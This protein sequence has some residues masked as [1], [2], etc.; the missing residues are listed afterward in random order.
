[1]TNAPAQ[2]ELHNPPGPHPV[3]AP[4]GHRLRTMSRRRALLWAGLA[5]SLSIHLVM[6]LLAGILF[7]NRPP[8]GARGR[9]DIQMAVV[10]DA[11]VSAI[12]N[13]ALPSEVPSLSELPDPTLP[14]LDG[15]LSE[16]PTPDFGTASVPLSDLGGS[17]GT[18]GTGEG[19]GPSV[20]GG[21]ASFFGVEARGSR[22]AYI[23]DA[24]GSMI[25]TRLDAL[26]KELTASIDRLPENAQ[27]TVIIYNSQSRSLTNNRWLGANN[28][29]KRQ[30]AAAIEAV[31]AEGGTEPI[32]AFNIALAMRPRPDAIY[33]MT[34]GEFT[35]QVED[36]LLTD[37]DRLNNK[38][39][40]RT[41]IHCITFII[42]SAEQIM[43]RVARMSGGT[44]THIA[45]GAGA[46][47]GGDAQ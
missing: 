43:R 33:F 34:D 30:L 47:S 20:G 46:V 8:A 40:R 1:M 17:G 2:T 26:K 23:V 28:R 6:A 45:A 15:A 12:V 44:Y 22:F 11:E 41:P 35:P 14:S 38:G 9:A 29:A 25:A 3:P 27:C 4:T 42:N 19:F 32:P 13:T 5:L 18:L 7:V 39:G 37:V 21:S 10:S 36:A 31:V 16:I 24:S